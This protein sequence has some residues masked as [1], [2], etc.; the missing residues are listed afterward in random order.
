MLE[1]VASLFKD[2]FQ[3]QLKEQRR[4]RKVVGTSRKYP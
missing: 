4:A 2:K 3:Y 1:K